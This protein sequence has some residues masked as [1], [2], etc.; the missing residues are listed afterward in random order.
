MHFCRSVVLDM[1]LDLKSKSASPSGNRTP[2]SRVT[3]GDTYHYTNEDLLPSTDLAQNLV[4]NIQQFSGLSDAKKFQGAAQVCFKLG[5]PTI[6]A[7]H[8]DKNRHKAHI[9]GML[10]LW[11]NRLARSAVNRKVG[12]SSPPRDGC[13]CKENPIHRQVTHCHEKK[14]SKTRTFAQNTSWITGIFLVQEC[15][16]CLWKGWW[17]EPTQG[18]ATGAFMKRTLSADQSLIAVKKKKRVETAPFAHNRAWI[19]CIFVGQ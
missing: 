8:W 17:F 13:F 16:T 12:G 11:R 2:V 19:T 7:T 9:L 18:Q 6:M 14:R 5:S 10:S 4:L 3:G 1:S 15:L